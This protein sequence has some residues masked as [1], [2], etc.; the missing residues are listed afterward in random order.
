MKSSRPKVLH[1]IGSRPMLMYTYDAVKALKPLHIIFVVG[2]AAEE[3]RRSISDPLITYITQEQPLGTGDAL[4][5]TRDFLR[6]TEG[7][8]I[9]VLNGDCPLITPE[10]LK[11]L[12]ENHTKD[13]SDLSFLS[14]VDSNASG[15]GRVIRD[16]R[17]RVI[18]IIEDKHLTSDTKK[19]NELNGGIY[20]MEP[21]VL[22]YLD[23]LK[24][25]GSSGEY[26]LTDL[27]ALLSGNG[28]RVNT[29]H[30]HPEVI[31]GVNTREDLLQVSSILKKRA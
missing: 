12:L 19:I 7:A 31:R 23:Q 5:C 9:V 10:A 14:F 24:K 22:D 18:D 11:T 26:Y 17:G 25:H 20:A 21:V 6:E 28:K 8:T 30:C 16:N 4:G 3:I 27:V 13:K 15:Y 1:E 2:H 29:Y